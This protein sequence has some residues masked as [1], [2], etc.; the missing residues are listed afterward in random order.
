MFTRISFSDNNYNGMRS[1]IIKQEKSLTSL[2]SSGRDAKSM[3]SFRTSFSYDI[4]AVSI[5]RS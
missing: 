3:L 4:V 2:S 5:S 1:R